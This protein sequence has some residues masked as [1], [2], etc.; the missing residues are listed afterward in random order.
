MNIREARIAAG[1]TQ[2]EMSRIFEIPTRTIEHW[3]A[4]TRKPPAYV[5]RLIVEKLCERTPEI[6][7]TRDIEECVHELC[8]CQ[9]HL[10]DIRD[11]MIKVG[12]TA[13]SIE[14]IRA[15]IDSIDNII[16]AIEEEQDI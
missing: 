5:E 10:T 13:E 8:S 1:L 15:T 11:E 2:A 16:E 4:G 12:A 14:L 3:E 9:N 7:W 6:F